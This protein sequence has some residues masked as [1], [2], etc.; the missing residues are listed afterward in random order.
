MLWVQARMAWAQVPFDRDASPE[1]FLHVVYPVTGDTL[2]F[3]KI[4]YAGS[5]VAGARVWVQGEEAQVFA[6]GAFVGMVELRAGRNDLVFVARQGPG[7]RRD[8]VFVFRDL[9]SISYPT[10]PTAVEADEIHPRHEVYILPGQTLYVQFRGSSGGQ[11]SCT[12]ADLAGEVHMRELP[13]SQAKGLRGVYRAAIV[14]PAFENV[15][16]AH[17]AFTLRGND[18]HVLKFRSRGRVH[19]LSPAAPLIGVTVDSSN[20]FLQQPDGEMQMALQPGLRVQIIA[21]QDKFRKVRLAR[22]TEGYMVSHSLKLLPAGASF[23]CAAVGSIACV[24]DSGWIH[25][26]FDISERVPFEIV[27]KVRPGALEVTFFHAIRSP[28]WQVEAPQDKTIRRIRYWQK[29][30]DTF[31]LRIELNQKQQW[32]YRGRY[33]GDQFVLS[34]RKT[35]RL[36]TSVRAPL[37]GLVICVD[38]GHGGEFEGTISATGVREK[39]VNFLWAQRV[40]WLLAQRGAQVTLTRTEDVAVSLADRVQVAREAGSHLF[41]SLHNNSVN[42]DTHPLN[43]RGTCTYFTLPH[44]RSVASIVYERLTKAGLK[45]FVSTTAPFV[46]TRQTDMIALLV[47]GGFLTHPED[48]MLLRD[49]EFLDAISR[50]VADGIVQFVRETAGQE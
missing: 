43:A 11:A 24:K 2:N 14:M 38:A 13:A 18:G 5:T 39:T 30:G 8:T 1:L 27:Q 40:A 4:R 16:P 20:S 7:V 49:S 42:P 25:L 10:V 32:G 41:V 48:E 19:L 9:G 37:T 44:A 15:A 36:A 33:V 34:I 31:V 47:E 22:K 17:V 45:P 23:P 12:I 26:Q 6:S 46:V 29:H 28:K 3:G 35:P 21:G 50:A